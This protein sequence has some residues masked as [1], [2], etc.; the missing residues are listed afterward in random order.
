MGTIWESI[1]WTRRIG[2]WGIDRFRKR[3]RLRF[4]YKWFGGEG[5]VRGIESKSSGNQRQWRGKNQDTI[6]AK[7]IWYWKLT[8]TCIKCWSEIGEEFKEGK[9]RWW[10]ARRLG[11]DGS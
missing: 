9:V 4:L 1:S 8:E 6:P 10:G 2:A 7:I 11:Q 3:I 5:N